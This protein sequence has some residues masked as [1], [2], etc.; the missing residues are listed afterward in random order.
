MLINSREI[1]FRAL[2][3]K[4][5][6][7]VLSITQ[8]AENNQEHFEKEEPYEGLFYPTSSHNILIQ[9][10]KQCVTGTKNRLLKQNQY[11]RQFSLIGKALGCKSGIANSRGKKGC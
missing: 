10:S 3:G 9:G 5:N 4:R 11:L 2:G 8:E 1:Y 7:K 6:Q